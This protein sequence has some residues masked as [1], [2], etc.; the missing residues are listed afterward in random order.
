[1]RLYLKGGSGEH[2]LKILKELGKSLQIEDTDEDAM[3][4]QMAAKFWPFE[5]HPSRELLDVRAL[6]GRSQLY[7]VLS[8][9]I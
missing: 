7:H 3:V 8:D 9:S 4:L 5:I 1:M 6:R 2:I